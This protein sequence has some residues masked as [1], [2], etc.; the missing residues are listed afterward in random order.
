[1]TGTRRLSIC[2][3]LVLAGT[4]AACGERASSASSHSSS[5]IKITA[6]EK[7]WAQTIEFSSDEQGQRT[8]TLDGVSFDLRDPAAYLLDW[9]AL[10]LQGIT[11]TSSVTY[12]STEPVE[13]AFLAVAGKGVEIHDGTLTWGDTEVGTV[14]AGDVVIVDAEGVRIQ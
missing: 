13:G 10:G 4:L 6:P 8:L 9:E 2:C 14:A 12:E 3:G 1:M 7:G 5:F 11:T